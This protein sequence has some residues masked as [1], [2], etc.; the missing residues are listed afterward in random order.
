MNVSE[1]FLTGVYDLAMLIPP[2]IGVFY[3]ITSF[4][5]IQQGFYYNLVTNIYPRGAWE[6]SRP[7]DPFRQPDLN[8]AARP[9]LHPFGSLISIQQRASEGSERSLRCV[10]NFGQRSDARTKLSVQKFGQLISVKC[11]DFWTVDG[12]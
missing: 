1:S 6:I 11:T 3:Y 7:L 4:V 2:L 9:G 12:C 8:S 10:Q 5:H